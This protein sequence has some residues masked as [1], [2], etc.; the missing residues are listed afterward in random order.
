MEQLTGI[1]LFASCRDSVQSA[2]EDVNLEI[3]RWLNGDRE[4][5]G[6]S[7]CV[8]ITNTETV[9][10]IKPSGTEILGGRPHNYCSM[11]MISITV[12]WERI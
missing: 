1:K 3:D 5:N 12:T 6:V 7:S 8:K 11:Y 2:K 9:H 10:S 4:N